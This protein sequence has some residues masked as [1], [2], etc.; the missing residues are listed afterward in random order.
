MEGESGRGKKVDPWKIY[1]WA[2]HDGQKRLWLQEKVKD[3]ECELCHRKFGEHSIEEFSTC[4]DGIGEKYGWGRK[5][6]PKPTPPS[7]ET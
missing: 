4:M 1:F 2:R 5:K 6:P 3:E 7:Q